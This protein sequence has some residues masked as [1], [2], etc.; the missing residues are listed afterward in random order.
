M[1]VESGP[2]RPL[3]DRCR[4]QPVSLSDLRAAL[5]DRP[6]LHTGCV[7]SETYA[8][9]CAARVAA[10]QR[11]ADAEHQGRAALALANGVIDQRTGQRDDART[12]TLGLLRVLDAAADALDAGVDPARVARDLR[13]VVQPQWADAAQGS[14]TEP[15]HGDLLRMIA[16]LIDRL[17]GSVFVTH[18]ERLR[19]FD[20]VVIRHEDR[21]D[22][23][24][25]STRE[26]G[27]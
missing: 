18:K 12:L 19:S 2:P 20:R 24:T 23:F 6:G 21:F 10:E 14:V 5:D 13:R 27:E 22:G 16:I 11:A 25:V 9:E 3:R 1:T 15:E 7:D 4:V 8:A 17:G 26:A